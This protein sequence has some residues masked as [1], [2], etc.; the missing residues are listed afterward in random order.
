MLIC[1]AGIAGPA[2][3][4]LLDGRGWDVCLVERAPVLRHTGFVIDFLGP[5]CAAAEAMGLL[6]RLRELAYTIS[7][8]GYVDPHGRRVAGLSYRQMARAVD[9]RLLSLKRAD[10]AQA[11]YEGLDD[12]VEVRFGATVET[13]AQTPDHVA[14]ILRRLPPQHGPARRRGRHP[15]HHA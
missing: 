7:D 15:L 6:P 12:R 8:V 9:G 5:G 4:R 3:A 13:I 10:L 14:V 11:L 2:M 1:G